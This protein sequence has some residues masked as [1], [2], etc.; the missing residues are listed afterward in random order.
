ME[1]C[2]E[3]GTERIGGTAMNKLFEKSNINGPQNPK[4]PKPL[5][6]INIHIFSYVFILNLFL[7]LCKYFCLHF[8]RDSFTQ[9][10]A[11]AL[12]QAIES[13]PQSFAFREPVDW[14]SLGLMDYPTIIKNPM[15]LST[16]K[17]FFYCRL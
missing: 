7:I 3:S 9:S 1:R 5:C 16:M 14:L 6:L 15:D 8:H 13:E 4:T 10:K 2:G 12:L 11:E 17:V